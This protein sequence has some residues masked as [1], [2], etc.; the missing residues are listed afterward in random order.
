MNNKQLLKW[1]KQ[2]SKTELKTVK[3]DSKHLT[4][5][6]SKGFISF[7]GLLPRI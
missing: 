7:A 1:L 5:T 3:K 4:K 6:A 2:S